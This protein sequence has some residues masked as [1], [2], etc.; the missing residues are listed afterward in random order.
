M[1]NRRTDST[2]V[3]REKEKALQKERERESDC[4]REQKRCCGARVSG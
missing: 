2:S 1:E 4:E 3:W